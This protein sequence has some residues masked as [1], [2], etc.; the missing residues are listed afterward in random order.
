MHDDTD[1]DALQRALDALAAPAEPL[2]VVMADGFVCALQLRP[3]PPPASQWLRWVLDI[4]GREVTGAAADAARTLLQSRA[5]ALHRAIAQRQWFDPWV[6]ELAEGD[7]D[8]G[9]AAADAVMPWAAGFAMGVERFALSQPGP[10]QAA[11]EPLA[12][13]Y[14]FLDPHD[15]PVAAVIGEVIDELEPP[16][17]L[18]DA[19][20]GLVRAVLLLADLT[21]PHA[22]GHR[23][24]ASAAVRSKSRSGRH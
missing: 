16:A 1:P 7:A 3:Q 24:A 18:D 14:R 12:L 11:D 6:F 8:A 21:G 20:E 19:V 2:D 22:A 4:D 10:R 9:G 13:I 17:T 5:D 23:S 15:W